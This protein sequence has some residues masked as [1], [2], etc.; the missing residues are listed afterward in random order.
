MSDQE[1]EPNLSECLSEAA[2][3]V[4]KAPRLVKGMWYHDYEGK[5]S[6]CILGAIRAA[7]PNLQDIAEGT[8]YDQPIA[9]LLGFQRI[10]DVFDWND[11]PERTKEEVVQRL[12]EAAEKAKE[13]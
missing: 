3:L 4:E 6:Y 12:R 1:M 10:I 9:D 8:P 2:G 5:T 7:R 11:V 13:I